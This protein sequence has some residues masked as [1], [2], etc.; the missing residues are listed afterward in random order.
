MSNNNP[1]GFLSL[2]LHAHLPY[3]RHPECDY[4]LEE[5]WFYEAMTECYLPLLAIF[6][7]LVSDR[8]PFRITMSLHYALFN[9]E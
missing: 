7:N 1:E 5:N 8:V 3:V 6:N 2:V 9:D 4:M